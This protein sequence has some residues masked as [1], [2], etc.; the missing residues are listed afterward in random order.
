MEQ[1]R[2]AEHKV[3]HV[4]WHVS[5][6]KLVSESIISR[7][8]DLCDATVPWDAIEAEDRFVRAVA[9]ARDIALRDDLAVPG[10]DSG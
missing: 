9:G 8:L 7:Q 5:N 3:S 2:S 10:H 6:A 4:A 1:G